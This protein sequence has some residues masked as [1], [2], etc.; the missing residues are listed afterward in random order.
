MKILW[1]WLCVGLTLGLSLGLLGLGLMRPVLA[2]PATLPGERV[3]TTM[4]KGQSVPKAPNMIAEAIPEAIPETI[5]DA[6]SAAQI[7]ELNCAGCHAHGGN[8]IRRGKTLKSHALARNGVD[9]ETAIA[10]IITQGK[11]IMS[12][13]GNR[14]TPEEIDLLA[15]YVWHQAQDDLW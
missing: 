11:G 2:A 6:P 12:A 3:E 5:P 9:S 15:T 14:F 1:Q 7:F 10:A 4:A 13:Y 8:I